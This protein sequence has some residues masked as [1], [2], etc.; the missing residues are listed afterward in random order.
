[1][2]HKFMVFTLIR[3]KNLKYEKHLLGFRNEFRFL[4]L[5]LFDERKCEIV[6]FLKEF[7]QVL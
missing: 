7:L 6:C 4:S 1:M 5:E 2:I 3:T